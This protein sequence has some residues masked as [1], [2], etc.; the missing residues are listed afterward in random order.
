MD[1]RAN[2]LRIKYK[3]SKAQAESLVLAG[4]ALPR[5]IKAAS[6]EELEQV[7][8]IGV[9]TARRLLGL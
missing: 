2:K 5:Q 1:A 6:Q 3:I 4:Y 8:D 7:R 9:A